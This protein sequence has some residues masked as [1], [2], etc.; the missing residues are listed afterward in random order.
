MIAWND[1]KRLE[2]LREVAEEVATRY[3]ISVAIHVKLN[4][5]DKATTRKVET[6]AIM[7]RRSEVAI[8]TNTLRSV[9]DEVL[10]RGLGNTT[11][12]VRESK[13]GDDCQTTG[14]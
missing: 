14:K 8:Y 10:A 2:E 1:Q 11:R 6:E 12:G 7:V 13:T 4:S 9:R 3:E 5:K